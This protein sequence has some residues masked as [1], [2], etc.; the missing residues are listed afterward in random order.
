MGLGKSLS[1]AALLHA[2]L[3]HPSLMLD[4]GQGAKSRL[5]RCVLLV[6]PTNVLSHW[7]EEFDNWT[8]QLIPSIRLYNLGAVCK[9]VRAHTINAWSRNGGILLVSIRTFVSLSKSGKYNEV[10]TLSNVLSSRKI[11]YMTKSGFV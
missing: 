1:C 2:L 11:E 5:I 9:E 10:S 3:N 4:P 7:E 6:V 8:G